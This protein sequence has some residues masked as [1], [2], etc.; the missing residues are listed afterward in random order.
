[1]IRRSCP[2]PPLTL[3]GSMKE[4]EVIQS[5]TNETDSEIEVKGILPELKKG[6]M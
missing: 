6:S 5:K 2:P 3:F 1:M 4:I